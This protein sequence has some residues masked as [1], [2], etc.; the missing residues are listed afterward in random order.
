MS[1]DAD[2]PETPQGDDA[3]I[4]RR[5]RLADGG[6]PAPVP[7]PVRAAQVAPPLAEALVTEQMG[8]RRSKDKMEAA[9]PAG[10][11]A[12]GA[13][14]AEEPVSGGRRAVRIVLILLIFAGLWGVLIMYLQQLSRARSTAAATDVADVPEPSVTVDMAEGDALAASLMALV[15]DGHAGDVAARAAESR[16]R[17]PENSRVL[18][19]IG[20]AETIQAVQQTRDR[21]AALPKPDLQDPNLP[22]QESIQRMESRSPLLAL[23]EA[24]RHD[25][26]QELVSL[27]DIKPIYDAFDPEIRYS[28]GLLVEW[29]QAAALLDNALAAMKQTPPADETACRLL[30]LAGSITRQ[31][32]PLQCAHAISGISQAEAFLDKGQVED[33]R[34]QLEG[35]PPRA[36]EKPATPVQLIM[37][38]LP[39]RREQAL[40]RI[41][42]WA[43]FRDA[44]KS[45]AALHAAGKT[46]EA[47]VAI[48]AVTPLIDNSHRLTAGLAAELTTREAKYSRILTAWTAASEVRQTTELDRRLQTCA[49][50]RTTLDATDTYYVDASTTM[51]KE[52]KT[53]IQARIGELGTRLEAVG[54]N[55]K[56][57]DAKMRKPDAPRDGLAAQAAILCDEVKVAQAICAVNDLVPSWNLGTETTAIVQVARDVLAEHA[58]Q[59]AKL[60][61]LA[62]FYRKRGEQAFERECAERVLLLG[63]FPSN[64]NYADAK[65][66]LKD[67]AP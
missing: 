24:H 47:L 40:A 42:H 29:K 31:P 58:D 6:T 44:L 61:S 13:A 2:K 49:A 50:L 32:E 36:V 27:P 45:S 25:W 33:A 1:T 11:P 67:K 10:S 20:L 18:T 14:T 57:I 4:R 55:Y 5:R 48:R 15:R 64:P 62:L 52:I 53:A 60:W 28:A 34:H 63:D 12:Q 54:R 51:L 7:A 17:F 59:G 9:A 3:G 35:Q 38:M 30:Q 65:A 66:L 26:G 19:A 46:A 39:A 41:G 56:G 22:L 16:Q 43:E 23:L 21:I 37:N 8:A